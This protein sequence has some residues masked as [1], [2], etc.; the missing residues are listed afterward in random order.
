M[1]QLGLKDSRPMAKQSNRNLVRREIPRGNHQPCEFLMLIQFSHCCG[2]R[3]FRP[4]VAHGL[5]APKPVKGTICDVQK[6]SKTV[7][8][9]VKITDITLVRSFSV[10]IK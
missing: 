8:I 5:Q 4:H 7:K 1:L 2:P 3:L 10:V 9:T 6:N